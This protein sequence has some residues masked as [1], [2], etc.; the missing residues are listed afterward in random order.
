MLLFSCGGIAFL[1]YKFYQAIL[2]YMLT[3]ILVFSL[4]RM[5]TW[6]TKQTQQA[7]KS[8]PFSSALLIY[9]ASLGRISVMN[10]DPVKPKTIDKSYLSVT[11]SRKPFLK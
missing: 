2:S 6:Y 8:I 1:P 10:A 5:K 3:Y 7:E 9:S 4:R 11:A